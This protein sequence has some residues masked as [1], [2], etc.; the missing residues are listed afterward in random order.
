MDTLESLEDR[1]KKRKLAEV[2]EGKLTRTSENALFF[3]FFKKKER[4]DALFR[5]EEKTTKR[6]KS[7]YKKSRLQSEHNYTG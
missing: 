5:S 7:F 4:I 6:W 2:S 3:F 1:D